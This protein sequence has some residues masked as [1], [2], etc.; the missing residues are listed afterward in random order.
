MIYN[1]F[2]FLK[3]EIFFWSHFGDIAESLVG[4]RGGATSISYS[5][6]LCN[7]LKITVLKPGIVITLEEEMIQSDISSIH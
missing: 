4:E 2:I 6:K 7:T 3:F 5:A 1:M